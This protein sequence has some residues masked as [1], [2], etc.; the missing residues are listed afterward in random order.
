M[1]AA[2]RNRAHTSFQFQ[3]IALLL[4]CI[5]CQA[6]DTQEYNLNAALIEKFNWFSFHSINKVVVEKLC[7]HKWHWS[8]LKSKTKRYVHK[9]TYCESYFLINYTL[10][11]L[12]SIDIVLCPST[13]FQPS[14][15]FFFFIFVLL[16]NNSQ[17]KLSVGLLKLI[18]IGWTRYFRTTQIYVS[19][20]YFSSALGIW[21][22]IIVTTLSST[23]KQLNRDHRQ[24]FHLFIKKD[25]SFPSCFFIHLIFSF[26]RVTLTIISNER[27]F[28]TSQPIIHILNQS[29]WTIIINNSYLKFI[30]CN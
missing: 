3:C 30:Q 1:V 17:E 21:L 18:S 5:K 6:I 11:N 12:I 28:H 27:T 10:Q 14:C 4:F 22:G 2:F 16:W 24:W 23:A 15:L 25:R 19:F 9:Y 8:C 29:F 7:C 13:H 20:W 26:N